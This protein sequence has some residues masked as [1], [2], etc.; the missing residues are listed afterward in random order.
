MARFGLDSFP[1]RGMW[2]AGSYECDYETS[3][4]TGGRKFPRR[5]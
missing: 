4:S 3:V 1:S 2:V 5:V